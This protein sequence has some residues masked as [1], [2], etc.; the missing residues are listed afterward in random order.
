MLNGDQPA[1]N[2]CA[3]RGRAETLCH[4]AWVSRK[5]RPDDLAIGP[6]HV[7]AAVAWG[8]GEEW[9]IIRISRQALGAP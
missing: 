8:S 7:Y 5:R 6:D 4:R 2:D 9:G 3:P 1:V